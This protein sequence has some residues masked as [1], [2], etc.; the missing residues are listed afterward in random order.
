MCVISALERLRKRIRSLRLSFL[1]YTVSQ[2]G[3]HEALFQKKKKKARKGRK[4]RREGERKR[5]R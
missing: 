3:L 1:A 5:E 2:P 4:E